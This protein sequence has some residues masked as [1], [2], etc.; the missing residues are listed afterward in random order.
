MIQP[1]FKSL[2]VILSD[3]LFRIPEYQRHY[4]WQKKQ[5]DELFEDIRKLHK[6]REKYEDRTPFMATIVCLKTKEKQKVGEYV[7]AAKRIRKDSDANIDDL[8][9]SISEIGSD[10]PIESAVAKLKKHDFYNDWQKEL[11][12]FFFRYEEYLLK[13]NGTQLKQ[14]IWNE[15][16]ESTPN[17]T[18]KHILPQDKSKFGWSHVSE[19]EHQDLLHSIGNLCLL[20]PSLNSKASNNCFNDKKEI[21]KAADLASLEKITFNNGAERDVWDKDS[22]NSRREQLIQFAME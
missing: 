18:I 13:A 2:S 9:N 12:Y 7:R 11:R 1:E 15:I 4:S 17:S 22:I 19:A 20:S 6:A 3:K 5:R 14:A 21:Y 8:L 10:F 16:W